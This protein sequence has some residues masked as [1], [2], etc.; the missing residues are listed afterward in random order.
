MMNN[1]SVYGLRFFIF[2]GIMLMAI[3]A[4]QMLTRKRPKE[5]ASKVD[6]TTVRAILFFSVGI[7][8]ILVGTGIIPMHTG[9]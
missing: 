4:V 6:V 5:R 1:I 9:H 8:A 3:A 7:L 2:G